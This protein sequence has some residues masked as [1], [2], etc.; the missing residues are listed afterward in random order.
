M[1]KKIIIRINSLTLKETTNK[2][3]IGSKNIIITDPSD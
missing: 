1:R 2:R 3:A